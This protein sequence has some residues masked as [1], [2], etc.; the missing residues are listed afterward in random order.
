MFWSV[1]SR[2]SLLMQTKQNVNMHTCK[3]EP[4][5][6]RKVFYMKYLQTML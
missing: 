2:Q 1:I 3:M 4:Y 6:F 5:K